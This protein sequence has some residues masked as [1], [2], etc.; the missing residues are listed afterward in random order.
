GCGRSWRLLSFA[1]AVGFV[2]R[3]RCVLAPSPHEGWSAFGALL[4]S[5][6]LRVRLRGGGR[7]RPL[8]EGR[9]GGGGERR[10][11]VGGLGVLLAGV[12]LGDG[13][14]DVAAQ[15]DAELV[16]ADPVVDAAALTFGPALAGEVA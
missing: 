16:D 1:R 14:V 5:C 15:A 10:R 8:G 9:C 7:G 11:A 13:D 12:A 2:V 3:G 6:L 4:G